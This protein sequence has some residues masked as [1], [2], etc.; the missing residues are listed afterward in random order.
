MQDKTVL[1]NHSLVQQWWGHTN[2]ADPRYTTPL[3]NRSTTC[4]TTR[5]HTWH[6]A[7]AAL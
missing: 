7:Q 5:T 6:T 3:P 1:A 2:L 4:I